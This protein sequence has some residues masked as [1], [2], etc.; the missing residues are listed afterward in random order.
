[1]VP[2]WLRGR[3]GEQQVRGC[4]VLSGPGAKHQGA[5]QADKR[6]GVSLDE[7]LLGN[8]VCPKE[9]EYAA[10]SF[11]EARKTMPVAVICTWGSEHGDTLFAQLMVE[12]TF[13]LAMVEAYT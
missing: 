9:G 13:C 8:A 7:C 2:R 4:P 3:E 11:R 12:G 6:T 1:M 10:D 5:S